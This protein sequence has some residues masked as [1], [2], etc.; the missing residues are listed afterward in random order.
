M[1]DSKNG[2]S[3]MSKGEFESE[4]MYCMSLSVAKSM[5]KKGL[6][7]EDEYRQIDTI[8]IKK[9]RPLLG[10]LLSENPLT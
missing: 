8:L 5:L 9:H 4:L 6:V 7:T 2:I 1:E 10:T 3:Y